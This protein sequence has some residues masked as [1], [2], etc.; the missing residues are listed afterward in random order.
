MDTRYFDHPFIHDVFALNGQSKKGGGYREHV[1]PRV[2]LRDKCLELY[3]MSTSI[4]DV[5]RILMDN[6]RIVEITPEEADSLNKVLKTTMPDGWTLGKS[7]PLERLRYVG[8]E[9]A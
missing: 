1:V 2:Y 8:I 6:L 5:T 7:D 3:D 9:I 4:D